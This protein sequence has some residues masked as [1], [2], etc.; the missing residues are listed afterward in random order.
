MHAQRINLLIFQ[1]AS[2]FVLTSAVGCMRIELY[3]IFVESLIIKTKQIVLCM[4]QGFFKGIVTTII[5]KN[6][7]MIG[8][9]FI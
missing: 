5:I 3:I 8:T 6:H 1:R 4:Q 9:L 2:E 7:I